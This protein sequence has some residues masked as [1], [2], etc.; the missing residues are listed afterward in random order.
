[1]AITP[2]TY[3]IEQTVND[4]IALKRLEQE[5]GSEPDIITK[6]I[7]LNVDYGRRLLKVSF[8]DELSK[9]ENTKLTEIVTRHRGIDFKFQKPN[10]VRVLEEADEPERRTGGN[11]RAKSFIHNAPGNG[12]A[13]SYSDFIIPYPTSFLTME[14]FAKEEQNEDT[15][16]I[17]VMP[18]TVIGIITEEAQ[19]GTSVVTVNETALEYAQI[20]DIASLANEAHSEEVGYILNINKENSTIT[21]SGSVDESFT[22]FAP[23]MFMITRRLCDEI[24]LETNGGTVQIGNSKIGGAFIPANTTFRL[25]YKNGMPMVAKRFHAILEFLY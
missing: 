17:D 16:T 7:D 19:V 10:L 24:T 15:F 3:G 2:Y 25:K 11:F 23:T 18:D 20:G 8:A 6:L 14:Y 5:I 9:E 4:K 22:E 21:F 1:M 12:Q 13:I